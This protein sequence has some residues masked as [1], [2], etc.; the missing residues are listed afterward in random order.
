MTCSVLAS[1]MSPSIRSFG[2]SP[3]VM[4]RSDASRSIISSSRVRRLI[5]VGAAVA[6]IRYLVLMW[7]RDRGRSA[8]SPS[9][10]YGRLADDL[11]ERRDP[12][13]DLEPSIHAEC[14]HP[15]IDGAIVDL[16]GADV[17][18]D[19]LPD[20]RRH[21]H[22]FVESLTSLEPAAGALLAPLAPE[23]GQLADAGVERQVRE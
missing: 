14:Q 7:K 15:L 13:H 5:P 2:R 9:C 23:E 16:R 22:D 21:E 10:L 4:C 12:L 6:D 3:A 17:L 18:E 1:V 20:V 11:F 19:Q 8:A